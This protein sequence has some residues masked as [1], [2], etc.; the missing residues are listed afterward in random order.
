M[1]HGVARPQ[2]LFLG[3]ADWANICN[4]FA[5]A[6]NATAGE[7]VARVFTAEPHPYGYKEDVVLE[8]G[9]DSDFVPWARKADWVI[10][11][12]DG[13]YR[14]FAALCECLGISDGTKLGI[15]HSG[16]NYRLHH[17]ACDRRDAELGMDVRFLGSDL[18]RFALDDPKAVPFFVPPETLAD[19]LH[20]GPLTIA[21]SPSWRDSKGTE[22]ILPVLEKFR[23]RAVIDLIENVDYATCAARRA[24]A[25]IFVDQMEPSIGGF[26]ASAVEALA[27]GCVV[28]A[29]VRNVC[30]EVER[31]YPRP[32]I[33]H[34][35]TPA[36][37]EGSIECLIEE[38]DTRA[39]HRQRSLFLWAHGWASQTALARYFWKHLEAHS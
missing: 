12:G 23:G 31:F 25:H 4:R 27:A 28:L 22:V 6:M 29:D 7:T 16:S 34:V 9:V 33:V 5:R 11:T 8:R 3:R 26:G 2:V 38:A 14:A 20:D 30:A 19:D 39:Y 36:A 24:K 21:H 1:G 15:M 18:Y 32:P 17:D 37:L 13:D 35:G 10:S